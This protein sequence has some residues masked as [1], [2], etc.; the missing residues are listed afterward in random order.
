MDIILSCLSP[1]SVISD[2]TLSL[3]YD[4]VDPPQNGERNLRLKLYEITD[5]TQVDTKRTSKKDNSNN[6]NRMAATGPTNFRLTAALLLLCTYFILSQGIK[7]SRVVSGL[8]EFIYCCASLLLF[9]SFFLSPQQSGVT[10]ATTLRIRTRARSIRAACPTATRSASKETSAT[11]A[12]R[13]PFPRESRRVRREKRGVHPRS[14]MFHAH[15]FPA[16][17]RFPQCCWVY[18]SVRPSVRSQILLH[19]YC[20]LLSMMTK[21]DINISQSRP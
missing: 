10:S 6:I 2:K 19:F 12:R 15:E 13:S 3:Y 18:P 14:S 4:D 16:P 11:R 9:F 21:T 1:I 20:S 8:R 17:T 7:L 5:D